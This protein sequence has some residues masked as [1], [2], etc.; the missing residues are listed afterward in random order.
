[1]N[2]SLKQLSWLLMLLSAG[3]SLQAQGISEGFETGLP[4]TAPTS[5]VNYTLA[6]GTWSI[7]QGAASAVVHSGSGAL[8]LAPGSASVPS[9]GS[10]PSVSQVSTVTAWIRGSVK[11]KL[12]VQKSVNGG[13]F[14]DMTTLNI[15]TTYSSFSVS[16]N[17]TSTDVRIRFANSGSAT[18]YIDDVVINSSAAAPPS[19]S[20]LSAY[21]VS[22]TGNDVNAG[23]IGA[24]FKTITKAISVATAGDS[25]ILRGGSH[26]Y[27]TT[28][29]IAKIGTA[30]A[31]Y[32]LLA[33]PGE[34]PV[35]DFSGMAVSSSNRGVSLSGQYW[36]V[37]G[38]DFYAAGDN[39]MFMSGSNNTIELCS[40]YE[41]HDT[42]LQI[43]SGAANNLILNCD[44]YYNEDPTQGN[45]DGFAPKLDVGTGNIFRGCRAWQNSD[46]GWDGLLNANLGQNPS[47]RYENCWCFMNGYTKSGALSSGN[48][49][50]FKMGGNL[51][52]H[53]ATLNNCLSAFNK[54]KGFDQNNN[55]GSMI[56]Y[57]CTGYKNGG[58]AG[59]GNFGMSNNDPA[60]GEVMIVKNSISYLGGASDVFRTV[61]QLTANSWQ[62]GHL[63]S[64]ADFASVDSIGL[65]GPRKADGSLPD[66]NFMHLASGSGLIDAGVNVGL[67]YNGAAPD[68]GCFETGG[69]LITRRSPAPA[70]ET[71]PLGAQLQ[72]WPNVVTGES[73]IRFHLPYSGLVHVGLLDASGNEV[74]QL[75]QGK[76]EANQLYQVVLKR[77]GVP[78]GIYSVQV[79]HDRGRQLLRVV[80]P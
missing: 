17:E 4:A 2:K 6:S 14:S 27:T 19:T 24:P 53:D 60:T 32:Y 20:D 50:G 70:E 75:W 62:D 40:F 76:I 65:R 46:D 35:L 26:L 33:Y 73:R 49:N 48:G 42:G 67:A 52:R 28:I 7:L 9:Y 51:E 11:G 69:A 29:S 57:N 56:L 18:I 55:A 63:V 44:S 34:K 5:P 45:A 22:P 64:G 25:I 1:M 54:A 43:G 47:T 71:A 37:K 3:L 79:V 77:A 21:Y 61:A 15:G 72:V 74:R 66:I 68:L 10:A 31:K 36:Y 30:T 23:T 8:Q 16:V 13:S 39:G 59:K 80:M 38:I 41:N 58:P 12:K 78:A